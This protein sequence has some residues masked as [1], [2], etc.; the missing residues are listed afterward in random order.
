MNTVDFIESMETCPFPFADYKL[1]EKS[2][3][4]IRFQLIKANR[5]YEALIGLN[6]DD[7]VSG[8]QSLI[9]QYELPFSEEQ[10]N[11]VGQIAFQGGSHSFIHHFKTLNRWYRIFVFSHE[12]SLVSFLFMDMTDD[13]KKLNQYENF[14]LINLD[15]LCIADNQGRFIKLNN[16]WEHV[17]G[18]PVQE[19]EG[20]YFLDFV[21]PDDIEPTKEA[22]Q[23][24]NHQNDVVNFTNRY[25]S[26]TGQYKTLEWRSHPHGNLIYAAARDITSTRAKEKE[27]NAILETTI[28][29]FCITDLDGNLLMVN[30]AF[31]TMLGYDKDTLLKLNIRN[32]EQT[33]T[34]EQTNMHRQMILSKG[35]DRFQTKLRKKSGELFDAAISVTLFHLNDP[36]LVVFIRD[37][38]EQKQAAEELEKRKKQFSSLFWDSPVAIIIHEPQTGE[39][40][41]VNNQALKL[42]GVQHKDE[43]DFKTLVSEP[44]YSYDE[45]VQ[46]IRKTTNEGPQEFEWRSK[47]K[48]GQFLWVKINLKV[49]HYE[50]KE[51]IMATSIDITQLKEVQNK[52]EKAGKAKSEFLSNMSHEIRT[53]LNGIIGFTEL[54]KNT[55]LTTTQKDYIESVNANATVLLEIVNDILDFSQ[56]TEDKIQLDESFCDIHL[57]IEESV[58][59]FK[60]S[61]LKKHLKFI[62]TIGHD[63]PKFAFIDGVRLK[64]ILVNLLSNALKFTESGEIELKVEF[65]SLSKEKGKFSFS[66][67]D[68]GIGMDQ[69]QQQNL[70]KAFSQGDASTTKKFGGTGLGLVLSQKIAKIMDSTI[71]FN[72]EP[73]K[74]STFFFHIQTKFKNT[75]DDE[76]IIKRMA[77]DEAFN[78]KKNSLTTLE[79]KPN[80]PTFLIVDDMEMSRYLFREYLK[81]Y[82]QDIRIL[83]A[84]NGEEAVILAKTEQPD[85]ILMDLFMP[86][87]DGISAAK[88]IREEEEKSNKNKAIIFALTATASKEQE[89]E[90]Y[91]AGMD[92]FLTKPLKKYQ[93][94]KKISEFWKPMNPTENKNTINQATSNGKA[95]SELMLIIRSL[96]EMLIKNELSA[97]DYLNENQRKL[98]TLGYSELVKALKPKIN[99]LNYQD[100]FKELM[101]ITPKHESLK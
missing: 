66:V 84:I 33:E 88:L 94:I 19:L 57:I 96:E 34:S 99:A 62:A 58:E 100:A 3:K 10:I 39:I 12:K 44:P 49:M 53:P 23:N 73:F 16:E 25:L 21:H 22:I 59:M 87:L 42:F 65:T 51:C 11:L 55:P 1:I 60:H 92:S 30:S 71:Q 14:F 6:S 2:N 83:E 37:T 82:D 50:G 24:L 27:L 48:N 101:K 31:C 15:L 41:E 95:D 8:N 32:L 76:T 56:M 80:K 28:D 40:I 52:A 69:E 46:W 77:I 64:Q 36:R 75:V 9:D 5:E 43:I 86:V 74:G 90:C 93:L 85:I 26:K 81:E 47:R 4:S 67:R 68:T 54:L 20:R 45:A 98:E 17:L 18:H 38:T 29:G 13:M 89:K 78:P 61:L 7:L 70:F 97:I 79:T 72:S 91:A 35:Y 63:I